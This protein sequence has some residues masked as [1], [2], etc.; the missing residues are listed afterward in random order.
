MKSIQECI[1]ASFASPMNTTGIGNVSDTSGDAL[2]FIP[3]GKKVKKKKMKPI[4]KYISEKLV[5]SKNTFKK[6]KC[7]YFPNTETELK[8]IIKNKIESENSDILDLNDINV[9]NITNL[10]FLFGGNEI[11]PLMHHIKTIDINLW[12]T[13]NCTDMSYMFYNCVKLQKINI[14]DITVNQ[15]NNM[16]CMFY[17]C[18]SLEKLDLSYWIT[19]NLNMM[20]KTCVKLESVGDISSWNM[21]NIINCEE[22]FENCI[23]IDNLG[24]ILKNWKMPNVENIDHMFY[25]CDKLKNIGN[26]NDPVKWELPDKCRKNLVFYGCSSLKK[27]PILK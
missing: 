22:M 4:K 20:F 17:G 15:V 7:K 2:C 10:S 14:S 18:K 26:V 19:S 11:R 13:S 23:S 27:K 1:D 25:L 3:K 9:S 8:D 24:D 21:S 6:P 5:L 16:A 12:D